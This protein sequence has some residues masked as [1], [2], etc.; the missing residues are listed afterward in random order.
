[1]AD[2]DISESLHASTLSTATDLPDDFE[3]PSMT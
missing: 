3:E 1:M 2:I